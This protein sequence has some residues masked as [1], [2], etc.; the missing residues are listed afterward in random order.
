MSVSSSFELPADVAQLV[1]QKRFEEL[2]DLWTRRVEE[3]P[4]DL[5]FFFGLAAA[6]KKK[7]G[8]ASQIASW[9]RL[10]ADYEAEKNNPDARLDVLGEIARMF[11]TDGE[12]RKE[13]EEA[14]RARF[15]HHSAL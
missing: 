15:A 10:L 14:I 4:G 9:L 13:L 11:P 8:A 6:A 5:P 12:I 2:E 1:E 3:M 7:G